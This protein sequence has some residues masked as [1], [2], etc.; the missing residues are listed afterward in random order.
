MLLGGKWE[1]ILKPSTAT[2]P[3][4]TG[5]YCQRPEADWPTPLARA[6]RANLFSAASVQSHSAADVIMVS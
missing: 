6:P 3:T 4:S 2:S 1:Y 5:R